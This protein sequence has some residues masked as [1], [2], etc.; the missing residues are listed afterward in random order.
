MRTVVGLFDRQHSPD[1]AIAALSDIGVGRDQIS[2]VRD[3]QA[4]HQ[5]S[6]VRGAIRGTLWGVFLGTAG[7]ALFGVILSLIALANQGITPIIDIG[8]MNTVFGVS[9]MIGGSA[10]AWAGFWASVGSVA[11]A[12]IGESRED[13]QSRAYSDGVAHGETMIAVRADDAQVDPIAE[14]LRRAGAGSVDAQRR[15]WKR[16]DWQAFDLAGPPLRRPARV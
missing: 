13:R 12:L 14:Q 15:Y 2:L 3:D 4:I 10:L 11:G 8:P 6:R 7:G 1:R 16:G 9:Y 5:V